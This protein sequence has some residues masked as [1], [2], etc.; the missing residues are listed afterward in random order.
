M[1]RL[2][3]VEDDIL[4][5]ILYR[6]HLTAAGFEVELAGDGEKAVKALE[7]FKPDLVVLDLNLPKVSGLEILK[8]IRARTETKGLPVLVFSNAL[9][10][11]TTHE[12]VEAG[13]TACL[14]KSQTTATDLITAILSALAASALPG[15]VTPAS[16]LPLSLPTPQARLDPRQ[17][18]LVQTPQTLAE[19]QRLC[20]ELLGQ[21]VGINRSSIV[22]G[23]ELNAHALTAAS[24]LAGARTVALLA[25]ALDVL[26]K[27]LHENSEDIN[28]STT[29]TVNQSVECIRA[30]YDPASL[31]AD[32]A[33]LSFKILVVDDEEVARTV[34][35]AA[36]A[37]GQLD[38]VSVE[39]PFAACELLRRGSFDLLISDVNMP[40]MNGFQ[41]CHKMRSLPGYATT[42]VIFVTVLNDFMTRVR[43][44]RS[45]GDDLI[46]KPFFPVELAVKA[47][48]HLLRHR[49]QKIARPFQA[50]DPKS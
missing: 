13:A 10:R 45:G 14:P 35:T 20:Q 38:S 44:A 7:R 26:L 42:P 40:G 49:T 24:A 8:R 36:L 21:E 48:I 37:R 18:F 33:P 16:V 19:M 12:A 1:K 46:A 50:F 25:S 2:L 29:R 43:S 47:L 22:L 34:I 23:L 17:D 32:D 15:L 39:D 11:D 41:L 6:N 3:F 9:S 30:L 27:E 31:K 5:G 28:A 4:T